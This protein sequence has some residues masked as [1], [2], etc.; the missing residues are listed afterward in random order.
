MLFTNPK[1]GASW[2]GFALEQIIRTFKIPNHD[3][4]FWNTYSGA[5]I[6]LLVFIKDKRIG[7]E[8]KYSDA[9]KLTKSMKISVE[10][11]SLDYLYV[12]YPGTINYPLDDKISVY[13]L[14]QFLDKNHI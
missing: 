11:L 9:P 2:E 5:E 7:F 4:F 1:L 8:F 10:D 12:I 14:K 13:G 6:D 3:C